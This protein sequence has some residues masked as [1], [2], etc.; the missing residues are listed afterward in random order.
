M[1]ELKD[2]SLLEYVSTPVHVRMY[3]IPLKYMHMYL[4]KEQ[5]EELKDVS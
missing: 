3:N 2:V 4:T 5:V 1:E